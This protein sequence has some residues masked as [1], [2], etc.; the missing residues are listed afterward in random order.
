[1]SPAAVTPNSMPEFAQVSK[2]AARPESSAS[3]AAEFAKAL[4]E[5]SD[6]TAPA[7]SKAKKKADKAEE[8]KEETAE[9]PAAESA[10]APAEEA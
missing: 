1:M 6:A 9:A 2:I 7:I 4:A 10:E 3:K 8:P 5:D